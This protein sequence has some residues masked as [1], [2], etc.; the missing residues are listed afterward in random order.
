MLR[1]LETGTF[2]PIGSNTPRKFTGRIIAA[3]CANL[4]ERVE[5]GRFREDLFYRINVLEI[6]VPPLEERREDIPPLLAHFAEKQPRTLV[7]T[8]DALARVQEMRWP[9]NVRQLRNFVDRLSVF[10]PDGLITSNVVERFAGRRAKQPANG[11]FSELAREVLRSDVPDKLQFVENALIEE[12]L[13]LA[14][15]NKTAAARLLGVHRKVV[16]RR[17]DR[18]AADSDEN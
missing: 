13:R 8:E 12:A 14:D 3:T 7:F 16:E 11:P 18:A 9:G 4:E 6:Y 17:T 10:A 1:V 15:G 2:R 5:S